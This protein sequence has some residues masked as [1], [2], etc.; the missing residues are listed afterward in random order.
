M[1]TPALSTP[2][3]T[4]DLALLTPSDVAYSE[5][6]QKH[7]I[8]FSEILSA[9]LCSGSPLPPPASPSST[10]TTT[11]P[12]I[13]SSPIVSNISTLITSNPTASVPTALAL[14]TYAVAKAQPTHTD[15]VL[16]L[17]QSALD[18]DEVRGLVIVDDV[19]RI[20]EEVFYVFE[21]ELGERVGEDM[22]LRSVRRGRRKEGME[23][24][25]DV[26]VE[27]GRGEEGREE[28][29]ERQ[30]ANEENGVLKATLVQSFA[31]RLGLTDSL[32]HIQIAR[33]GLGLSVPPHP[34]PED[35]ITKEILATAALVVFLTLGTADAARAIAAAEGGGGSYQG[36]F[37]ALMSVRRS[38]VLKS[39]A[40]L[41]ALDKVILNVE[42]QTNERRSA[43][44]VWRALFP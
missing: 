43:E 34:A 1:Y 21:R 2:S 36:V 16:G 14:A 42:G 11:T 35:P 3:P 39:W 4:T 17:V 29:E 27:E 22:V 7:L 28:E 10:S 8:L 18:D 31:A 30:S 9:P 23:V 15:R 12:N 41:S 13:A 32:H 20:P 6:L 33:Q 40:A 19:E 37:N 5:S 44:E 38:G 24:E 26:D 25:V